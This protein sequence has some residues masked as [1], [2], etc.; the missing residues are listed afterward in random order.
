MILPGGGEA[1]VIDGEVCGEGN[2]ERDLAGVVG[3]DGEGVGFPGGEWGEKMG[4]RIDLKGFIG[5]KNLA[6]TTEF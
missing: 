4:G 5:G 6:Y 1:I 3:G 2:M